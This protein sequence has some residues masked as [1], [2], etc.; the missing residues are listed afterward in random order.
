MQ[1]NIQATEQIYDAGKHGAERRKART[2]DALQ[3]DEVMTEANIGPTTAEVTSP[4]AAPPLPSN[5][6]ALM[7]P[8]VVKVVPKS[9]PPEPK[10]KR[11]LWLWALAGVVAI[12]VGVLGY[13][14]P[15][16][17]AVTEVTVETAAL[18]PVSR[19]LAVNGRIAGERSVDVR[20]QVSGTLVSVPVAEGDAVQL[21]E[22]VAQIDPATQ[23][24]AVR[25]AMAGL[26]AA[27]VAEADAQA[28]HARNKA[29][30][31]NVARVVLESSARAVQSS[32]Q[33]VAR[34]TALLDQAQIQLRN[35]TIHAPLSGNVLVLTAEPGQLVDP[36]NE[37]MTIADLEHLVV[38]TDV[39]ESYATQVKVGQPAALQL[40]G[41]TAV[42]DGHVSFVSQKVDEAT[43]G[44][45]VKLTADA[46][47]QAPI[48][49][50]VTANITV[51][52]RAAA[53]T[54]P[55]AAIVRDANGTGVLLLDEG[56]AVRRDVMLID[57]PAARLIVTDGLVAG[58]VVIGD[59][60]G[61]AD[62]KAVKVKP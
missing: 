4:A 1:I 13:F 53:I 56:K 26:D 62:G 50:T 51:D 38:E 12:M 45:E 42:L 20:P 5:A 59:A 27:Q 31:S 43:G 32:A 39:D 37:L 52:E 22:V 33:E 7:V 58:D 17:A 34:T 29:L 30:G 36:A 14:Q 41:E 16:V 35:Y 25:Q 28:E 2:R 44:L 8:A 46:P 21:G 23:Q 24:A 3:S 9:E 11:R 18:G 61:I 47:L 6:N 55:R 40:S 19:V 49:L 60:T 10:P 54:V 15:W 57:W 48:G